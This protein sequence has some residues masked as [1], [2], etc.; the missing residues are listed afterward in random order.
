MVEQSTVDWQLSEVTQIEKEGEL[1]QWCPQGNTI[2]NAVGCNPHSTGNPN[3]QGWVI[4]SQ[5]S[6]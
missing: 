3:P 4:S 2:E 5:D 6:E 1:I